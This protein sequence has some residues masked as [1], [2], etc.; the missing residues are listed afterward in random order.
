MSEEAQ[1]SSEDGDEEKWRPVHTS[2]GS[3]HMVHRTLSGIAARSADDGSRGLGRYTDIIRMGRALWQTPALTGD[4]ARSI[5]ETFFDD[6]RFPP[7][8]EE[9]QLFAAKQCTE[10]NVTNPF[11]GET[12]PYMKL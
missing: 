7:S 5:K 1:D 8:E 11:E 3:M 4:R 6:G 10:E 12:M 2:A 9:R